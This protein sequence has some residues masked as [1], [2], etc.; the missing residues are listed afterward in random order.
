MKKFM[1]LHV[2]LFAAHHSLQH[3]LN[4][5]TIACDS[6]LDRAVELVQV[7]TQ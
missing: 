7:S 3:K 2:E 6:L 5:S 4:Q 1:K